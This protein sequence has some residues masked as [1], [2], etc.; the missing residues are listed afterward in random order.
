MVIK[1]QR[2]KSVKAPQDRAAISCSRQEVKVRALCPRPLG[3]DQEKDPAVIKTQRRMMLQPLPLRHEVGGFVSQHHVLNWQSQGKNED[4]G[5][6][7]TL[8]V[9]RTSHPSHHETLALPGGWR[10]PCPPGQTAGQASRQNR[11][12]VFTDS[13]GL[14]LET[15]K[16]TAL[17]PVTNPLSHPSSC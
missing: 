16:R 6:V 7:R 5:F 15:R 4:L 3:G 12:S 9:P 8:Q 11:R 2:Q 1:T 14:K 10:E 17:Y 13:A